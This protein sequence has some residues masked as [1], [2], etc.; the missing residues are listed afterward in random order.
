MRDKGRMETDQILASGIREGNVL[1]LGPGPGYLGLEWLSKTQNT[2]LTGIEI[3]QNMIRLALQNAENYRLSERVTYRLGNAAQMPFEDQSFDAVF[4]NGSLH[5]WEHPGKIFNEI[6]RVLKPGG[7]LFISD[8]KRDL[9]FPV[10]CLFYSGAKPKEIRE[11][12]TSSLQAAYIK[13]ELA[14]M[15]QNSDLAF[16]QIKSNLFGLTISGLKP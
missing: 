8:L 4:S 14:E 10:K 9:S 3:S 11:G 7:R 15:I 1:E 16:A 13:K 2:R 12:L 5:E 6:H